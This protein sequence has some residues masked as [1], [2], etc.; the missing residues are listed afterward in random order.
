MGNDRKQDNTSITDITDVMLDPEKNEKTN[1]TYT[2]NN[3]NNN[4][5]TKN[6]NNIDPLKYDAHFSGM[7]NGYQSLEDIESSRGEENLSFYEWT[8]K[9]HQ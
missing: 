7:N 2:I 4:S 8:A 9:Y 3:Q 6:I 1:N 5:N